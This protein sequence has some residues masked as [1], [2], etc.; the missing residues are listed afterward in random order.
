MEL[1]TFSKIKKV[2][3]TL[4]LKPQKIFLEKNLLYFSL[5]KPFLKKFLI[6]SYNSRNGT[7][8]PQD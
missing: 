5:K 4:Q 6:F 8:W 2:S 7:F 1:S 3:C